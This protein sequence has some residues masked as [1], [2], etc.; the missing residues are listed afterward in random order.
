MWVQITVVSLRVLLN[1][2]LADHAAGSR[3]YRWNTEGFMVHPINL[4]SWYYLLPLGVSVV[5][6]TVLSPSLGNSLCHESPTLSIGQQKDRKQGEW[7]NR[8]EECCISTDWHCSQGNRWVAFWLPLFGRL[9]CSDCL[10]NVSRWFSVTEECEILCKC[11]CV[12]WRSNKTS[13]VVLHFTDVS[14][15]I[16]PKNYKGVH[17]ENRCSGEQGCL[18]L[19]I[20]LFVCIFDTYSW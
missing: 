6:Q 1:I 20:V 14:W 17:P 18:V 19:S 12:H 11:V 9:A 3:T 8:Q 5:D 4:F 10:C 7:I 2:S 15:A 16:K 13:C